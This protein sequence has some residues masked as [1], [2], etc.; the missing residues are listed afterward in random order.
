MVDA[1]QDLRLGSGGV[2]WDDN[3]PWPWTHG[4]CYT[5][6]KAGVGCGVKFLHIERRKQVSESSFWIQPEKFPNPTG[7]VS[8]S[9][10]KSFRIHPE[11]FPNTSF[12]IHPEKFPNTS[13]RIQPGKFPNPTGKVSEST[14]KSFRIQVSEYNWKSF[15]RQRFSYQI[16]VARIHNFPN[17]T[18]KVSES[19]RKV[20]ESTRKSF[21]IHREKFPNTSFRI[22]PEKFPNTTVTSCI[23]TSLF[24]PTISLSISCIYLFK[25]YIFIINIKSNE[26]SKKVNL[27]LKPTFLS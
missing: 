22:Q 18:G 13:F 6:S 8:E 10:R 7:Q 3:V 24:P 21:R 2:G 20:S 5:R 14:R 11:K 15:R 23:Y 27:L 26:C 16:P 1:T 9:N 25:T 19:N 4:R 17:T 12:R